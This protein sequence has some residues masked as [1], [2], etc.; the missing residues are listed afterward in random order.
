MNTC[1][2]CPGELR[3][4]GATRHGSLVRCTRCGTRGI[5][6][7]EAEHRTAEPYGLAYRAGAR[8]AKTAALVELFMRH[9]GRDTGRVL[10]LGC[11]DG[12]FLVEV[13]RAGWSVRGIDL[14]R[15]AIEAARARSISCEM[16]AVPDTEL[17]ETFDVITMW[18]LIE[19]VRDPRKVGRWVA[20]RT[21][22]GSRVIVVTPDAGSVF[23][24]VSAWER[25][26][27]RGRSA[28]VE[29]LCLNSYHLHRFSAAGLCHL[30]EASGFRTDRIER[31]QL[32]SL[33][34]ERYLAGFA[35]GVPGWTGIAQFDAMASRLAMSVIATLR[36]TNKLLYVGK[37]V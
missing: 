20:D 36:L 11:G 9:A 24:R 28:R 35:P 22:I 16:G 13:Q 32:F 17:D 29:E 18:D 25:G 12:A 3:A 23:D 26:I 4:D 37:R 27:T 14:D 10:D 21:G 34:P 5:R 31:V 2:A 8:D 19:H 1:V 33:R 15:G 7:T 6:L 30:M